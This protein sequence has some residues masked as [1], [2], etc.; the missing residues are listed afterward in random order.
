MSYIIYIKYEK[1]IFFSG[2]YMKLFACSGIILALACLHGAMAQTPDTLWTCRDTGME[3]SFAKIFL[4]D[5]FPDNRGQ[6]TMVDTGAKLDG[7]YVNFNYKFSKDSVFLKQAKG[8]TIYH[9]APRPGYAG[10]KFYWDDG[11]AQLW[12]GQADMDSMILWHKGPLTGHKVKMIWAQGSAGCG[13]PINYELMGEFKASADWKRESFPFP[14]KRLYGSA[15]D[16]AFVR[17]GL[18]ELR[19]LIYNDSAA[20]S[21]SDTSKPGN[22]KIDNM[23]FFKKS[24]GVIRRFSPVTQFAG[25]PRFFVPKASGEV[26]LTIFSLQGEQLF[27]EPVNVTAGKKYDVGQFAGKYSHLPAAWIQCVKITGAGVNITRK[28][29]R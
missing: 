24:T 19:M 5:T 1:N 26:T 15:P 18:F 4:A 9:C 13:T 3:Y 16:S 14:E 22:F 2:G 21:V 11:I 23:Y 27:K 28:V 6:F 12:P 7:F 25:G 8:D 20:G 17:N 29:V 10:F